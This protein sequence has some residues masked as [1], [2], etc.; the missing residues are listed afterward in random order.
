MRCTRSLTV[1][2]V[3]G[4]LSAAAGASVTPKA[5]QVQAKTFL[6]QIGAAGLGF[7]PTRLPPHYAYES[8]SVT[9][10]PAGLDLS[11]ADQRLISNPTKMREHEISF[12]TSYVPNRARTCP[13]EA[14]NTLQSGG[15]TLYFDK[16][17]VWRCV[18]TAHG[19]M[20]K[21]SVNG[22]GIVPRASLAVLVASAVPI[23]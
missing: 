8:F 7:A 4:A 6:V 11:F 19:H 15:T 17:S 9:G 20:V 2:A 14:R 13:A 22:S 12:D 23:G 10:S 18:S 21:E 1:V 3:A 5:V 16:A